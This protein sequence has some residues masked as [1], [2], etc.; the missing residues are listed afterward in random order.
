MSTTSRVQ[1]GGRVNVTDPLA[2]TV[3]Y[4]HRMP[5]ISFN[6]IFSAFTWNSVNE[7]EGGVE[8]GF[9]PLLRAFG[10]LAYVSYTDAKSHRWTLGM[11]A[12][13]GS[14]SYVGGDGYAGQLQGINLEGSYPLVGG[15]VIPSAG[16]SYMSYRLSP[17]N[18][19]RDKAWTILLGATVRPVRIFSFDVQG[20]LLTN[21][22]VKRDMRLLV[23]LNYWFAERLSIFR[24]EGKQ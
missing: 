15:K 24:E 19:I 22:I 17:D 5:R 4:V 2:I 12:G 23:K 8:Y 16:V 3:D 1:A 7:I 21:K 18:P 10:K 9:T 14:L 11:N 20:Q 13:Y 6:S